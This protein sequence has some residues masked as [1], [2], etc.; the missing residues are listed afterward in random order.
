LVKLAQVYNT[1]LPTD[2]IPGAPVGF[3]ADLAAAFASVPEPGTFGLLAA[4][5]TGLLASRRRRRK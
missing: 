4:A 2:P 3:G 5:T 1:S